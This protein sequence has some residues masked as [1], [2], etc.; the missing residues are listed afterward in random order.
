MPRIAYSILVATAV[1]VIAPAVSFAQKVGLRLGETFEGEIP[2]TAEPKRAPKLTNSNNQMVVSTDVPVTL[3]AGQSFSAQVTVSGNKRRVAVAVK[4]SAGKRI[5]QTE[6][7]LYT[8]NE[9]TFEASASGTF[10]IVV[11]SN[12][13]GAF[14]LRVVPEGGEEDAEADARALEAKIRQ[15]KQELSEA[16]AKLDALKKK[17]ASKRQ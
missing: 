6:E 14:K 3:K 11:I 7:F 8:S 16:E 10:N 1:A 17:S 5:A 4:D 13:A 15:L 9:L 2:A 12:R